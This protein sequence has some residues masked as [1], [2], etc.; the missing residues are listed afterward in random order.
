M[1]LI[2]RWG[3]IGTGW[4]S[5]CRQCLKDDF[6]LGGKY[7]S[8]KK[9][10][11]FLSFW[12]LSTT[13]SIHVYICYI[14][15]H[16]VDFYGKCIGKYTIYGCYGQPPHFFHRISRE[17]EEV[18]LWKNESSQ[19]APG[20]QVVKILGFAQTLGIQSPKLR[21]VSWNLNTEYLRRWLY[22]PTAH[23]LTRWARIPRKK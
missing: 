5:S 9:K 14:Y 16:L 19:N 10:T 2:K 11:W 17:G 6:F 13:H 23:H 7:V 21:M 15:P 4:F 8:R 1:A 18:W 12:L 20:F 3:N 22:T